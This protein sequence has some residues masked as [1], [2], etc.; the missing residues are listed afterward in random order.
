MNGERKVFTVCLAYSIVKL[1]LQVVACGLHVANIKE[2]FI[3]FYL[4]F[5]FENDTIRAL[6]TILVLM[7]TLEQIMSFLMVYKDFGNFIILLKVCI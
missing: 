2:V 1:A 6:T 4:G 3:I 7:L 5:V